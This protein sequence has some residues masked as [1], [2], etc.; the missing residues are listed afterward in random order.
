[1][2]AHLADPLL[3]FRGRWAIAAR[4]AG[5]NVWTAERASEDRRSIR[6]IVA[7]SA[8]ELAAKLAVADEEAGS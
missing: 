4:P 6:Y 2:T 7:G 1:V 8:A 3:P 5:L